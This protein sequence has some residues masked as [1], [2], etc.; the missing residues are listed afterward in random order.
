MQKKHHKTEITN[1]SSLIELKDYLLTGILFLLSFVVY[2]KTLCPT[3]YEGDSGE[4]LAAIATLGI[5]H[6]TGFPL[7]MLLGKLFTIIIPLG[8]IAYRVNILSAFFASLSVGIIYLTLKTLLGNRPVCLGAAL[9]F[10]FS[11]TLWSHA[12]A[13]RVYTLAGFFI[14]LLIW[15]IFLWSMKQKDKY[16]FIFA[17]ILG[18]ALGTHAMVILVIPVAIAT[19]ATIKPR[20]FSRPVIV[21][22]VLVA[23]VLGG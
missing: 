15:T 6:P 13:A 18:L 8:D 14:T 23:L 1:Q 12:T 22:A 20:T 2:I 17:V 16:L 5:A 9:A 4:I 21:L 19:I 11:A 7:Y 3:V 10:A